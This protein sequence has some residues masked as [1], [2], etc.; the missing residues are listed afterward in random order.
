MKE[1]LARCKEILRNHYQEKFH[2]LIVYGSVARGREDPESDVDLLVLLKEPFE[3]F[4]ELRTLTE[5][6]FPLQLESDRLLSA[7]PVGVEE[8]TQG[9]LQLYRNA[10]REGTFV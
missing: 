7:K 4:E 3:Y 6:L 9:R 2:G 8:F 10:S 5:I 1:L